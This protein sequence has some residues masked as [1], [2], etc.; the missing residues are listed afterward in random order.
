MDSCTV[1]DGC[2]VLFRGY[3]ADPISVASCWDLPAVSESAVIARAFRKWSRDLQGK[4]DGEYA[5]VIHDPAA[6]NALLTHDA[7]GMVPL[8]YTERADGLAFSTDLTE[9]IDANNCE[10]L[11]DEYLADFL[12][13][14]F[15]TSERTPYRTIKRLLPG[16]SLWWSE[17]VLRVITTWRP[18]AAPN[19]H[20]GQ[21]DYE[22]AF[23]AELQAAVRSAAHPTGKTWVSLSGGLDSSSITCVAADLDVPGLAAYSIISPYFPDSDETRWMQPV[24]ERCGIP[25]HKVDAETIL[26]FSRLPISFIGEPTQ[27]VL[28]EAELSTR[29]ALLTENCVDVLMTGHGGDGVL[30]ASPGMIPPHLADPLFNLD[31]LA[32]IRALRNWQRES[33]EQRPF[34]FWVARALLQPM[35]DHLRG[36]R[37]MGVDRSN[38][39]PWLRRDYVERSHLHLRG[40][41]RVAL[42]C[43][44]PSAQAYW[45]GVWICAL[46]LAT[47]SPR[48]WPFQLRNPLLSRRLVEFMANVPRDQVLQPRC[49]RYLQRR[50][51]KGILPEIVRRRASKAGGTRW[52]VEGLRRSPE[53]RDYL[54]DD[55]MLAQ[56]GI[57]DANLWRQAVRQA[58][59]GQT[60]GDKL[61]IA[62]IALEVWFKQLRDFACRFSGG[63]ADLTMLKA[64][65]M[66]DRVKLSGL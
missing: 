31:P 2:A 58:S 65:G 8:F 19:Q 46:A 20:C 62:A 66:A 27:A 24:V 36:R 6:R 11:D 41:R 23:R 43:R 57:A 53:W 44:T 48:R 15:I 14:G 33:K 45:D 34:A 59:V 28:D 22:E 26:P 37:I 55:P 29:D 5:A 63:H 64:T 10:A 51:L 3:L 18:D 1:H 4:V 47:N 60:H 9:L 40:S 7:L 54:S 42:A 30:G 12:A 17:G 16:Q 52:F 49:D 25:W 38:L 50:A 32:A 56:H 21:I 35:A 39:P 61:F 13:I